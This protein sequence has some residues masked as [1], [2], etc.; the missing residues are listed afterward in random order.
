MSKNPGNVAGGLKATLNN[1]RVSDEA[2]NQARERLDALEGGAAVE[3]VETQT[4]AAH[5]DKNDGNVIG[6]YKATLSNPR[7]SK[8]AKQ[9]AKEMLDSGAATKTFDDADYVPPK[10]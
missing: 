10:E 7:V 3:E 1:P 5:A 4:S 2:K 9:H 6:G 8:E